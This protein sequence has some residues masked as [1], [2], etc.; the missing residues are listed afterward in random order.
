MSQRKI[1]TKN[2]K[3]GGEPFLEGTRV[4][5]SDITIKYEELDYT[6]EQLL[7]AY[8]RLDKEDIDNALN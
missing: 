8:P 4:R 1:L 2:G 5:V 6:K 3:L 7:E